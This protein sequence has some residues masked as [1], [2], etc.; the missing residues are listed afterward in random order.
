TWMA[1]R[2]TRAERSARTQRN[3]ANAA[4]QAEALARER[5]E[6]AE[7]AARAEAEKAKA[8]NGFLTEDLLTQAE[9]EK[10]AV[11]DRVTLL[12]VVDRAAAKVGERFHDQ[13]EAESALRM[14]LANMY[15]GLGSFAK[16]ERQ[17]RAA[18]EIERRHRGDEAAGT[19]NALARLGHMQYHLGRS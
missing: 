13:P 4:R 17:A 9:P 3:A 10:N 19:L 6:D 5:A 12:E 18:L 7:Q 8:I 1:V 2:A 11:E 14:L 15:H 16:A